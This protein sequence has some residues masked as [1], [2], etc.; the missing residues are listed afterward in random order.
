[1]KYNIYY[2][3]YAACNIQG[4]ISDYMSI[5]KDSE[6]DVIS[7]AHHHGR[8]LYDRIDDKIAAV[9]CDS[10]DR[11]LHYF[12]CTNAGILVSAASSNYFIGGIAKLQNGRFYIEV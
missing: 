6:S 3:S 11:V 5:I 9:V 12:Q 2:Q 8:E 4:G 1:M 7:M 10:A